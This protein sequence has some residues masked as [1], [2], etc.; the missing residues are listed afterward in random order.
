MFEKQVRF[1]CFHIILLFLAV[2][3][4]SY[5]FICRKD[6]DKNCSSVLCGET[7]YG[8]YLT[9]LPTK[10]SKYI[11]FRQNIEYNYRIEYSLYKYLKVEC[12]SSAPY[13]FAMFRELDVAEIDYLIFLKCPLPNLSFSDLFNGLT[14]RKL[15]FESRIKDSMFVTLFE[16]LTSLE[17]LNLSWNEISFLPEDI[18]QN[19]IKIEYLR[20]S[21]NQLQTMP[22]NIFQPLSNLENLE[23][24]S[25]KLS[26]LPKNLF[27][28]LVKLKR[29]YLYSNQLSVL[30]S[31]VFNNLNSLEVLELS[32]NRF[33]EL[34][35]GI[36]SGLPK[37][38]GLGLANNKFKTLPTGLFRENSALEEL[39][40]SGNPS[41]KH[42]PGGL[43]AGLVNL[44][45]LSIN[46]CNITRIDVSF[47]S[48]VPSLV[49]IKMRNNRLTYLPIG[50]FQNNSNLRNLQMLFNDL[51]SLPVGLFGK[52]FNLIKLNLFKNDIQKLEAGIFDMLVSVQEIN[53][54][55]NFIRYINEIVFKMLKNLETLILTG[56]QITTL[57]TYNYLDN[58]INLKIIDLSKN[59]LT[60]FPDVSVVAATNVKLIN[61]KYNQISHLK[62]PLLASNDVH[63][64]L[65]GNQIRTVSVS[66]IQNYNNN[67]SS[68]GTFS[69][70]NKHISGSRVFFLQNNQF[71]CDCLMLDFADHL[72]NSFDDYGH[73]VNFHG[74]NELVC[75]GPPNLITK[76]VT[77][78]LRTEFTCLVEGNCPKLCRCFLRASDN[79][80]I[81]NCSGLYQDTLPLLF[82]EN[83]SVLHF[84][85]NSLTSL[86][87]LSSEVYQTLT[88]L[89]LDS[90]LISSIENYLNRVSM[91]L[92][93]EA[94]K[95]S[96]FALRLGNNP[97]K[98]DCQT[99]EFKLWLTEHLQNITDIQDIY[100]FVTLNGT[101][102]KIPLVETPDNVLCPHNDLSQKIK[103]ITVSIICVVLALLLFTISVLYYR[104]KQTVI[105]YFYFHFYGVF[106]CFFTHDELDENKLYDAFISYCSSDSDIAFN[107]LKELETKEPY[108]KL[109]THDRDWLAGN[110]ISSN[111][112]YSVQNSKRIILILSKDFVESAWF[113]IEFHAAHYQT[114]E[115][116]VNRLIVV[117]RNNLPPKDALDKDL[118]YLLSTKTYL[119]WK[120]RWFWEKLRYAM[121]H[122]T[123]LK[124]VENKKFYCDQSPSSILKTA[125]NPIENYA[126][127]RKKS[128][129][130]SFVSGKS[131]SKNSK[132]GT[133]KAQ[134]LQNKL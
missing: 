112:V 53:L 15:R 17:S 98:C 86:S 80:V 108:F 105:A 70:S 43:L 13:K 103:L 126:N 61:L 28:N 7:A 60:T 20:L 27:R 91:D 101:S 110:A 124:T 104:N 122:Q 113:H 66:N 89:Y 16:D 69:S 9:C 32:G 83:T 97:W 79:K 115:D 125:E 99:L 133:R 88:E 3:P 129:R 14:V 30:P 130:N 93:K 87:E 50:T 73:I 75:S 90:N 40:L 49:E 23:L 25:N 29:I 106:T 52:Q 19:L 74:S 119:V 31:N 33:T 59:N 24:G 42:F 6:Y 82:P 123:S 39:K 57:E 45:N 4:T 64:F 1:S 55:Y 94:D 62:I 107:I 68:Y 96:N 95:L 92:I 111:I 18:F 114:L 8:H 41:F 2:I 10:V 65:Q 76:T 72:R 38:R 120:E 26:H 84:E 77:S 102:R 48:Q 51:I 131:K 36:F 134:T 128:K 85:N 100:C 47:F 12:Y 116:K 35:E 11:H 63:I 81:V 67:M 78:V 22:E 5:E 56:N 109:C 71:Q 127:N 34:P 118:Q 21:N 132:E 46:D 58:L 44:K 54:G 121:P 37:L 117:V